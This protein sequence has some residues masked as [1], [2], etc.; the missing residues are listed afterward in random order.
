V[1]ADVIGRRPRR[2]VHEAERGEPEG[3]VPTGGAE[4]T[5]GVG[6]AALA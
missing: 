4:P 2:A 6:G 1:A 5:G 3:A